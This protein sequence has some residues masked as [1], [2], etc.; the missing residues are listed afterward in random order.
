MDT[1]W[2]FVDGTFRHADGSV[3]SLVDRAGYRYTDSHGEYFTDGELLMGNPDAVVLADHIFKLKDGT[4]LRE[5]PRRRRAIAERIREALASQ[6][7]VVE[8]V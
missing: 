7:Y 8:I 4:R 1:G 3:V 2:S 6:G 5:M